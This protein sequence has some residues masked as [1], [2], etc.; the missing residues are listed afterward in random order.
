MQNY[1]VVVLAATRG[2]NH[3][4]WFTSSPQKSLEQ[5]SREVISQLDRKSRAVNLRVKLVSSCVISRNH[6]K[7]ASAYAELQKITSD[8]RSSSKRV[9]TKRA[10]A[11]RGGAKRGVAKRGGAKRAKTTKA[12]AKR[13]KTTKACAK[14]A[15]TTKASVKAK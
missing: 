12:S 5:A 15:K 7:M 10:T 1:Y 4:V 11:E 3:S 2:K 14:R 9:D 8:A 6:T 13:A